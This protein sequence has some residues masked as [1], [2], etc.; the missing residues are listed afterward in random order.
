MYRVIVS[1]RRYEDTVAMFFGCS[2]RAVDLVAA[3]G[4]SNKYIITNP[5]DVVS[6]D[7]CK[8]IQAHR[9]AKQ[10]AMCNEIADLLQEYLEDMANNFQEMSVQ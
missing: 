2:S 8:K 4:D 3:I 9:T 6:F 5:I 1:D 10:M 7:E